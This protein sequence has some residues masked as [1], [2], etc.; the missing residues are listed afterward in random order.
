MDIAKALKGEIAR[1][2]RKEM[3][4]ETASLKNSSRHGK[5][6]AAL[7]RRIAALESAVRR[8]SK[9]VAPQAREVDSGNAST[10]PAGRFSAK[11]FAAHRSRLALSAAEMASL[12]GVSTQSVYHWEQG[13]SRPRASQIP[14]IV[15]VRKMGKREAAYRLSVIQA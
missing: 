2:A 13:K 5:E 4:S 15:A 9:T 3:R 10:E 6:L 1:I 8:L 11:G 12:L 14:A 7:T